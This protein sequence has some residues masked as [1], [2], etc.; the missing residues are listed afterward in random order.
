M[1][2][3]TWCTTL[4]AHR[5]CFMTADNP[6]ENAFVVVKDC[7]TA[8]IMIVHMPLQQ[9]PVLPRHQTSRR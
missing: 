6:V 1:G 9:L 4:L 3:T 8:G 2:G 7:S 5:L